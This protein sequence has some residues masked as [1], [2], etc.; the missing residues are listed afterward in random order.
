LW[1]GRRP[2]RPAPLG[3]SLTGPTDYVH[4]VAFSPDG[5]TLAAG[6]ADRSVHL[7]TVDPQRA[8]DALCARAGAPLT[9][10]E[11]SRYVGGLPY[12]PPCGG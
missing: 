9:P 10:E 7:W 2:D 1:D 6:G 3:P 11:W 8:A 4:T 5:H 12:D